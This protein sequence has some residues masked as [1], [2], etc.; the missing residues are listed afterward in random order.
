LSQVEAAAFTLSPWL[1]DWSENGRVTTRMGNR[2]PDAVPHGAFPCR[3]DDR[4]V[5]VAVW[6]D[7]AWDRMAAMLGVDDRELSTLSGRL[8]RIEEVEAAVAAWTRSRTADEVARVLQT[9]GVEAVPVAD[10]GDAFADAQL[11]ARDHFVALTH[12]F[13]GDGCYERNG[14]RL[15]EAPSGYDRPSPTLGQH[16]DPVLGDILGLSATAQK[17]LRADGALD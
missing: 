9:L 16:N 2:S 10:F 15:S 14:F 3:G 6:D 7:A 12:P 17:E 4:W 5:A 8:E 1:L 13:L 11:A